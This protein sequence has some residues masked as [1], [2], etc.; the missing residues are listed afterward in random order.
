MFDANFTNRIQINGNGK[1]SRA[2]INVDYLCNA[3]C[4]TIINPVE[5]GTY[6]L[7]DKNMQVLDIVD[8]LK[9]IYPTLEFLFT[10]QHMNLR[11]LKVDPKSKLFDQIRRFETRD[12]KTELLEFKDGFSF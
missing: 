10:N 6:N 4:Q 5:S 12:L 11:E 2:F 1:Q 3:L 9:E 7:V 8:V